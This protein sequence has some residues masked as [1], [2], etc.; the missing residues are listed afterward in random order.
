MKNG[1]KLKVTYCYQPTPDGQ[2]RLA[3]TVAILL[4][5]S[6]EKTVGK[7]NNSKKTKCV[8]AIQNKKR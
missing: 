5:A 3:R 1:R 7:D 8:T 4:R 6:E 2:E